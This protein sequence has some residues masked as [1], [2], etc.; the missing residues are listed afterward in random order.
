MTEPALTLSFDVTRSDYNALLAATCSTRRRPNPAWVKASMVALWVLTAVVFSTFVRRR[1]G[2]LDFVLLFAA[3]FIPSV[4][5]LLRALGTQAR[6]APRPNGAI[7][8]HY[9]LAIRE[10]GIECKSAHSESFVRWTAFTDV[11]ETPAHVILM[12][13]DPTGL[14]IP[15]RAL[16]SPDALG[17]L[18]PTHLR[19]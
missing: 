7:L 6:L 16:P 17:P 1:P 15:K 19:R 12:F 4:G 10:D 11:V 14:V 5:T 2:A 18:L 9:E 13:D 3:M 8:T